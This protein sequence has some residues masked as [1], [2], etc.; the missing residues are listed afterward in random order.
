M[1]N[2]TSA[3]SNHIRSFDFGSRIFF[4]ERS[5]FGVTLHAANTKHK[6]KFSVADPD[7]GSGAFLT[8]GSGIRNGFFPDP[9]SRITDPG[10][11]DHILKSFLTI[12]LVKSSIIL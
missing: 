12:F 6:E 8:P 1:N 9:G 4:K 2:S 11:Q 3:I 5:V 10:S 7:P